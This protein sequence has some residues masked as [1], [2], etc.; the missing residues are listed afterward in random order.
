MSC[1]TG[2]G[3]SICGNFV[4]P[5]KRKPKNWVERGYK[6]LVKYPFK[7]RR[8]LG[9]VECDCAEVEEHYQPYYGFSWYHGK[10]CAMMKHLRRYPGISN[11][12]EVDE[13]IAQSE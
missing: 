3:I 11:L 9:K 5:T 12:I 4:K 7:W 6:M 10:D 13:C 1:L 8:K 2:N